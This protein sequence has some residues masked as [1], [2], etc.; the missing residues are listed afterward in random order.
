MDFF[1]KVTIRDVEEVES[2]R[3]DIQNVLCSHLN[4]EEPSVL[5][6]YE[7]QSTSCAVVLSDKN[8]I[9]SYTCQPTMSQCEEHAAVFFRPNAWNKLKNQGY[10]IVQAEL[11]VT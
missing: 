5:S 3:R 1:I 10:K 7:V 9:L 4:C 2:I 8:D 11:T 6:A